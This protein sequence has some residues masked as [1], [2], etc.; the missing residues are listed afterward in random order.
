MSRHGQNK[1]IC[2]SSTYPPCLRQIYVRD[3]FF[4]AHLAFA[5]L[6]PLSSVY[7]H[8]KYIHIEVHDAHDIHVTSDHA[9]VHCR[10]D[11]IV[12]LGGIG[13]DV[14]KEDVLRTAYATLRYATTWYGTAWMVWCTSVGSTVHHQLVLLTN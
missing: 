14:L 8:T 1:V 6:F 11:A 2:K 3:S 12:L 9:V 5:I 4:S 13:V 7:L 10:L